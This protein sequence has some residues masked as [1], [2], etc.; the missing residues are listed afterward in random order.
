MKIS[1]VYVGVGVAGFNPDRPRG[2]REGSWISH[3]VASIGACVRAAG[4]KVDLIDMRHLS[5]FDQLAEMVKANPAEVYGLSI[6]AV[7]Y[8][9][10]L[11]TV[12]TIKTNAP[13]SKI[14]VGGIQP[15]IFPQDYDYKVIDTVVIGE[16]EVTF[17]DLLRQIE[18]GDSLPKV[19]RGAK[20]H[21]DF[22]PW[23]ARDLFDYEREL[24]CFF[25][26]GQAT[27]S[28]TMLAGRGCPYQCS[29]CQ[30]AENAVFGKPHR[31]RPPH[32]V[33]AELE[34]LK[35]QYDFKSI[36][37]WDDTFTFNTKWI[38]IFCDLYEQRKIKASIAACSR[39]DII[40]NNE[41]MVERLASIGLDWFVI[42]LESGSQRLLDL[43]RKG[44]TVEQNIRAGEICRKYG[45]KIFGTF[46]FGLP[47]ETPEDSK[48]TARMINRIAPEFSSP[49][50]YTPI[51]GTNL[52]DFCVESNLLLDDM[53]GRTIE[54]TG[55]F[56]PA[57]K[58][59]D[60][61]LLTEMMQYPN[62]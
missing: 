54:R 44:T 42:G 35:R 33:V 1:L 12:L 52:Y 15:S 56:I 19:I 51:K 46:M 22:L 53:S 41:A 17:I 11:Q 58:N 10:G 9:T 62:V 48:A 39:A 47:T 4:Y 5:G 30:P 60:Y 50:W 21:L 43:I 32:D 20:P 29:Y 40:C 7:D 55:R 16:G 61:D 2:D 25:A 26:P 18:A 14:I 59:V 24:E 45:I 8:A 23:V 57:I 6:S 36:T 27:P 28:V 34:Y 13:Q 38:E 31:M 37:F 3:G 49:F